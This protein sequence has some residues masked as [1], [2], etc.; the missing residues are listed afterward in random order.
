VGRPKAIRAVGTVMARNPVPLVIPCHR[1]VLSD[2]RIGHYGLG[3]VDR[4]RRL[5][6]VEGAIS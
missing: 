6:R 5:L 2:G 1:V 3:G 4:K